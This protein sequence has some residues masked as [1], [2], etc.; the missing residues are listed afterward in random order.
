LQLRGVVVAGQAPLDLAVAAG[1]LVAVSGWDTGDLLW[2]VV[3]LGRI[4][5][6]EVLVDGRL[7]GDHRSALAVGMVLIPDGGALASLLTAY[8]NVLLPVLGRPRPTRDPVTAARDA[9]QAV[10][11]ADSADHLVEELSGGQQ[12][13]VAIARA[14]A[15]D[16]RVL[17]ADQV[18]TDLDPANRVRV[19]GLLRDLAHS[20]A[21]VLVASDDPVV[22]EACDRAW[23]R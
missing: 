4:E 12:Q 8:E 23:R 2:A 18:T 21:A 1:E 9:L 3:G 16:P 6:G 20:G 10:G 5:A 22:I 15:C 19:L 11:L 7:I 17:V 14:L 13:R